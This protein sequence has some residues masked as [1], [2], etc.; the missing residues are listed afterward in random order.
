PVRKPE[1]PSSFFSASCLPTRQVTGALFELSP[2]GHSARLDASLIVRYQGHDPFLNAEVADEAAELVQ[3]ITV[4]RDHD[5]TIQIWLRNVLADPVEFVHD[6]AGDKIGLRPLATGYVG[7][8]D[9]AAGRMPAG[10]NNVH[11]WKPR[12]GNER[13]TREHRLA[14]ARGRA[15]LVP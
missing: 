1:L 13:P 6:V 11:P 9:L 12:H 5:Q 7:D 2:L 15:Q 3:T 4:L 8:D 14:N 10:G